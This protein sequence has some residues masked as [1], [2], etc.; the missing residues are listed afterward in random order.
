MIRDITLENKLKNSL[1]QIPVSSRLDTAIE[2]GLNRA[3]SEANNIED[4]TS[5]FTENTNTHTNDTGKIIPL[6]SRYTYKTFGRI[7][8]SFAGVIL[9]L[10]IM[11]NASA[12]LSESIVKIPV[13]GGIVKALTFINHKATGGE[14]TDGVNLDS[15]IITDPSGSTT[16][17]ENIDENK[18]QE[19]SDQAVSDSN[20]YVSQ[21]IYIS[22]SSDGLADA[23]SAHYEIIEIDAPNVLSFKVSG[24]RMMDMNQDFDTITRS[25]L[26]EDVYS[27]LTLDDSMVRFNMVLALGVTFE[28][29]EHSQPA[30]LEI[31]LTEGDLAESHEVYSVRSYSYPKGESFTI[32]EELL[33]H[34]GYDYHI[35]KDVNNEYV[36]EFGRFESASKADLLLDQLE[37]LI[38]VIVHPI[39]NEA[40]PEHIP[41]IDD[42]SSNVLK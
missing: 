7:V 34:S 40:I 3:R 26:V 24:I 28:V 21:S 12:A 22:F 20:A 9:S 6:S 30:Q 33:F 38:P 36:Y 10:A 37:G 16:T 23:L 8:A 14:I 13:I 31:K 19:N 1:N 32:M 15:M 41:Y 11:S 25:P 42:S 4:T 29:F 5:S 18:S 39:N 27:I 2:L 35:L 17:S